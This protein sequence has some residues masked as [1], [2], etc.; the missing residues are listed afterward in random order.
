MCEPGAWRALAPGL[1]TFVVFSKPDVSGHATRLSLTF[2]FL[3]AIIC[4]I[5][6]DA[7]DYETAEEEIYP[8]TSAGSGE[9]ATLCPRALSLHAGGWALLGPAGREWAEA[10]PTSSKLILRADVHLPLVLPH[11]LA[12][13]AV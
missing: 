3:Q 12:A 11:H 13:T 8:R 7:V 2:T 4:A 9:W 1:S 6:V 5:S 10:G